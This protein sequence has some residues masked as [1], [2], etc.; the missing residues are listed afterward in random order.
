MLQKEVDQKLKH[1]HKSYI[2]NL[3]SA[4]N[5]KKS[6]WHYLK[7]KRQ[8]NCGISTLKN[9]Q[10]GHTVTDPLEKANILNQHFKSVFTTDDNTTIHDKG[11][12]LFPSLPQFQITEQGV[13]NILI[14][15]HQNLLDQILFIHSH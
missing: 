9:P 2:S 12:S 13:Y 6:L 14:A 7:T 10:D 11:P 3:I 4:S 15:T 1:Q 5:N 8:G